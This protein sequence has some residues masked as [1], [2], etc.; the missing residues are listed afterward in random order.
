MGADTARASILGTHQSGVIE[1]IKIKKTSVHE[2][3]L[4]YTDPRGF[5]TLIN[6]V[7]NLPE[8]RELQ[9]HYTDILTGV[10]Q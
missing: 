4:Y 8:A 6:A 2:Y 9:A 10:V 7:K 1:M 3:G 5:T